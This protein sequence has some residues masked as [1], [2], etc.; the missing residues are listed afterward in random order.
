[1]IQSSKIIDTNFVLKVR[2]EVKKYYMIYDVEGIIKRI[3][4]EMNIIIKDKSNDISSQDVFFEKKVNYSKQSLSKCKREKILPPFDVMIQFCNAFDCELG[5]LLGEYP[6]KKRRQD[7]V[8]TEVFLSHEALTYLEKRGKESIFDSD[9]VP[10]LTDLLNE[11][12]YGIKKPDIPEDRQ[13]IKVLSRIIEE[14]PELIASL[15]KILFHRGIK[16][17]TKNNLNPRLKENKYNIDSDLLNFAIQI[18][19]AC[20]HNAKINMNKIPNKIKQDFSF[21]LVKLQFERLEREN[22]MLAYEACSANRYTLAE[23]ESFR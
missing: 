6:E 12:V 23:D 9:N 13:F 3:K 22:Q 20:Q 8:K 11:E 18:K 21:D 14:E 7:E 19:Y 1:M 10:D 15:G 16:T 5:Y 2:V 17:K 4:E